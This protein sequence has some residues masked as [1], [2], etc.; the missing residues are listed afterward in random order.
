MRKRFREAILLASMVLIPRV[1]PAQVST[2]VAQGS[3]RDADGHLLAGATILVS[4]GAGVRSTAQTN[5]KGEFILVAPYGRYTLSPE[6]ALGPESFGVEVYVA[7][8]QVTRVDLKID[9][10]GAFQLVKQSAEQ[11][12]GLWSDT[13]GE[14]AYPEGYSLQSALL[15]REPESDTQPLD[16]QGL[17]DNRLALESRGALSWTDTQYK[18]NGMDATDSYQPGGAAILPDIEAL[19]DVLVRG[20]FAQVGSGSPGAEVNLFSAEA[21]PSWHGAVS[22]ADTGSLLTSAN[23]PAPNKSGIVQQPDRFI[24]FTRD[25]FEAGGPITKWADVFASAAGQWALQTVP[26]AGP[27][28]NQGSQM[29]FGDLRSRIRVSAKDQ[30]DLLY[31]GSRVSLSDGGV[32]ADLVDLM[33]RRMAPSFVSPGG[34]QNESGADQFNYLQAGWTHEL[35]AAS[36]LGLMQV[37]YGYSMVHLN[38]TPLQQA[39]TAQ[40][41]SIEL[42]GGMV[43][44]APPLADLATRMRQ[45]VRGAW[46]LE[47]LA[48]ASTRHQIAVGAGWEG[49]SPTDRVTAPSDL[50]LVT[51]NGSAAFVVEFNTPLVSR[52][53]VRSSSFSIT[54]HATFAHHLSLDLGAFADFSRGSLPAQSSPAGS[55]APARTFAEQPDLIAWNSI[56][57]RAGFGWVVPH[58]LGLVVRGGYFRLYAPLAGRYL[59]FGN[60]NSLGGSQYQWND[61]N[62]D[63]R[64]EAGEQGALLLH[65]GGPYSSISPSLR[66]PY[67]DQFNLGVEFPL[68][69]SGQFT[70]L[71]YHRNDEARLAALDTGVAAAA[72]TPLTITDPGDIGIPG[73]PQQRELIVYAQN[74]A[75]FGQDRYLLSNPPGVRT[76]TEGIA[77]DLSRNWR[78]LTFHA[79]LASEEAFG[80]TNPGD[81][82]LEND[83]GVVGALLMDPNTALFASGRSFVDRAYVMKVQISYRLPQA[84]SG[85]ELDSASDYLDGLPFG[86]ELLVTGLPQG[87]L[88]VAATPRGTSP[89][90]G[91]RADRVVNWNLRLRRDFHVPGGRL[92]GA[93]DILNVLDSDASLQENDITGPTFLLRL[94]VAVQPPRNLR[95]EVRYEF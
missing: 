60:P 41:S 11:V 91:H 33:S 25:R 74:P 71:F 12:L 20:G 8:L 75:T 29:L 36:H 93:I 72:F 23:L 40:Q 27:G 83:P 50:N 66:R 78:K 85:I 17:A 43:T 46:V 47:P 58:A 92:S 7:P 32:P 52:E 34:F 89:E 48:I 86:R 63:G 35:P 84:W 59:D 81:G 2:G 6:G 95:L 64:F 31:S 61:P 10:S 68:G 79:S 51:V 94:P 90:G 15:N 3:L 14:R 87:P 4:S 18:L 21:S 70:M 24:W 69:H 56:S 73:T 67:A 42:L 88:L 38:T 44:G 9:A 82:V 19:S 57:P 49:S 76:F 28:T 80:P 22:S 39:G 13:T 26:L 53:A 62:G 1:L 65:F 77:A 37:R 55:F 54:D 30:L 45:E 5:A 16:F